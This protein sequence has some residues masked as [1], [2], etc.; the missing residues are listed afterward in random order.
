MGLPAGWRLVYHSTEFRILSNAGRDLTTT[1]LLRAH[2]VSAEMAA[3]RDSWPTTVTP[4]SFNAALRAMMG[5]V[6][7]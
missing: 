2:I 6:V 4:E 7:G 1:G 3:A 5:F